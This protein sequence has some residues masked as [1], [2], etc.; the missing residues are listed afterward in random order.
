MVLGISGGSYVAW[1]W[2]T[3]DQPAVGVYR[4]EFPDGLA[5]EEGVAR[6]EE[7]MESDQ[8]MKKVV[9]D[10]DLVTRFKLESEDEA[11]ARL[12]EKLSL[13]SMGEAGRV[14]V[15]YRDRSFQ[16]ALEILKAI[17]GE[18]AKSRAARAVLRPPEEPEA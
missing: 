9:Q 5:F 6:V 18:F 11:V 15:M 12:R 8:V 7:V 17:H 2:F 14:R 16:Q 1:R 3:R 10:L 13:K 4:M